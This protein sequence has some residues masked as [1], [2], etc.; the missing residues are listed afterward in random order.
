MTTTTGNV[1]LLVFI[2]GFKGTDTT[3]EEFPQRLQHLLTQ[4]VPNLTVESLVFPAYEVRQDSA[5]PLLEHILIASL[6]LIDEGRTGRS[7]TRPNYA[8]E[9]IMGAVPRIT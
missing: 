8:L 7:M 5:R 4:T 3:F 6:H 2:H 9:L 1:L